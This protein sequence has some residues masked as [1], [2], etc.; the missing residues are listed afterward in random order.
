VDPLCCTILVRQSTAVQAPRSVPRAEVTP[1]DLI[2]ETQRPG[3]PLERLRRVDD[4]RGIGADRTRSEL[5]H[6]Q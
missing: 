2:A 3:V 5:P 4:D 6:A 1:Q